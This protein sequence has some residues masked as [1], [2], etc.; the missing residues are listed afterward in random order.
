MCTPALVMQALFLA[1]P[2]IVL[3]LV[4]VWRLRGTPRLGEAPA[5]PPTE[6]PLVSVILPARNEAVHIAACIRSLRATTWPAWELI[7]VDDGSTDDT[8]QLARGASAGDSRIHV[9]DAPPLPAGWFGKQ[10]GCH[11]GMQQARGSLLLFTDADTRHQPD[12]ITR[13]VH[14]RA[15]RDADL[16]SVSG[17]QTMESFWERAVQPVV[18]AM[19]LTRFGGARAMESARSP[20]DVV[21]NGQCFLMTRDAYNA[22]GGHEAVRDTVAEDLM[23]AQRTVL[24]GRRVSLALGREQ[25]STRMY[26]GLGALFRGWRKNVYAGGRMA[27]KGGVLGRIAFP[28]VLIGFP[29]AIAAP[30]V[31]FPL[32]WL[33]QKSLL[34]LWAGIAAGSILLAFAGAA[35]F[36]RVPVWRAVLAPVGAVAFAIICAAAIVRGRAVEWK[37][38]AYQSA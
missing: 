1:S 37:G 6:A 17:D 26:D 25:L 9:L 10:W 15:E 27:M 3:P 29:L 5:Q 28:L 30:F 22:V 7:V 31:L 32:G 34:V 14:V 36:G 33:A 11:T 19:I 20:S 24:V 21:A 8:G 2:W 35:R 12:L 23:L 16:I 18:F 38:R 13:L 4:V